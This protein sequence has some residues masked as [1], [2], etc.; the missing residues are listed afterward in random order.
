MTRA[1]MAWPEADK[2]VF[3]RT[4]AQYEQFMKDNEFSWWLYRD[5]GKRFTG[6]LWKGEWS[7]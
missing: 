6:P 3:Y 2:S 1:G 4:D 7:G 5:H